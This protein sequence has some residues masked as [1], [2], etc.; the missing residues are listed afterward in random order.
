MVN[1]LTD[2]IPFN[3]WVENL[4][5]KISTSAGRNT[6]NKLYIKRCI[7]IPG[8]TLQ[9]CNGQIFINNTAFQ[10]L[11]PKIYYK[12]RVWLNPA[13]LPN[14]QTLINNHIGDCSRN[15]DNHFFCDWY[16]NKAENQRLL[17]YESI[18]SITHIPGDPDTL[19][20]FPYHR[21]YPWTK[22]DFGP[23][24]VPRKGDTLSLSLQ[25]I[26]LYYRVIK[27]YE[28][29]SLEIKGEKIYINGIPE[30]HYVFKYNYYF[31][32]GDNWEES[33]DSRLF[34]LIPEYCLVGKAEIIVYSTHP[35][36][37][38]KSIRN[39]LFKRVL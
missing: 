38:S 1:L 27:D 24:E 33:N 23:L 14:M 29:N 26:P 32:L 28:H 31:A 17:Q 30:T 25:N 7:A 6:S 15:H 37:K 21:L 19:F 22:Y 8:D 5:Y 16:L 35:S 9:I 10:R 12:N 36:R 39:Q 18:D 13:D 11:S 4:D 3:R 34:G 20:V 2:S